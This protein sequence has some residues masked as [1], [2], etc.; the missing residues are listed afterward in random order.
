M[1]KW[2]LISCLV[3][4]G[5]APASAMTLDQSFGSEGRVV[6]DFGSGIGATAGSVAALP[7]GRI[8]AAGAVNGAFGVARLLPDGTLDPT[9][10]HGGTALP[11]FGMTVQGTT[12]PRM[13]IQPD[14]KI[15]VVG[16]GYDMTTGSPSAIPTDDYAVMRLNADGALDP[17]F[18]Q[19]G[20]AMFQVGAGTDV[21]QAVAVQ[22]D[23]KIVVAGFSSTRDGQNSDFSVIRLTPHGRLDTGFGQGG[24]AIVPMIPDSG[25]DS[26][27]ALALLPGGRI[28]LAGVTAR[29]ETGFDLAAVR[30]TSD[31]LPDPAFGTDGRTVFALGTGAWQ[32]IVRSMH[33]FPDG[34]F[35][36]AGSALSPG[37]GPSQV[38]LTHF[39]AAG[40]ADYSHIHA[41]GTIEDTSSGLVVD[42]ATTW[43][44][45][46]SRVSG[47]E[48]KVGVLQPGGESLLFH[49]TPS[50]DDRAASLAERPD[51][52]LIELA[53]VRAP[54][55]MYDTFGLA[56]ILPTSNA[57]V[58]PPP[59][60]IVPIEMPA[61]PVS[62]ITSP[63]ANA[64]LHRVIILRGTASGRVARVDI[65]LTKLSGRTCR[66][67][68]SARPTWRRATCDAH[69]WRPAS[70]TTKW[71]YRLRHALPK[72]NYR[73]YSAAVGGDVRG[74][75]HRIGFTV[76]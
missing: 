33:A 74:G 65:A 4:L 9:F 56:A 46:D 27:S 10:G 2:F 3:L 6:L 73:L 30:M 61:A 54:G 12:P 55:S 72:G 19:G 40:I 75:T 23:G 62:R 1:A 69:A 18:G 21:A 29:P 43:L 49:I 67:L 16:T 48:R 53:T 24:A 70:G 51:G 36:I 14:G 76:R 20:K 58:Q 63:K 39:T 17:D 15:V 34:S 13:A 52:S 45:V 32:E 26:A 31:G 57:P 47:S 50:G 42:A 7:D 66:Q 11:N 25:M 64:K 60:D 35:Q 59:A 41:L 37:F 5:A 22:P 71:T 8:V 38:A 44:G 68:T 28:L